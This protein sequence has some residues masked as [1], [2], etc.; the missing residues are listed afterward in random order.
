M[1]YLAT[2]YVSLGKYRYKDD[3]EIEGSGTD[4]VLKLVDL[5]KDDT[6][7]YK[8]SSETEAGVSHT[9]EALLVVKGTI[10]YL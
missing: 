7:K 9:P 5:S 1:Y 2:N 4:G 3:N 6:G 8:C 10:L